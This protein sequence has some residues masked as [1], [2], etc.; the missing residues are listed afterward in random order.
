MRKDLGAHKDKAD[1]DLEVMLPG[2]G[3]S[4]KYAFRAIRRPGMLPPFLLSDLRLT[5]R[6]LSTT[7]NPE[8]VDG[9]TSIQDVTFYPHLSMRGYRFDA[10]DPTLRYSQSTLPHSEVVQFFQRTNSMAE[11]RQP[12][13]FFNDASYTRTI[14]IL[15]AIFSKQMEEQKGTKNKRIRRTIWR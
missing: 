4:S 9:L 14:C 7:F 13:N 10:A 15:M 12:T 3:L 6:R 5:L 8:T 2:D 1:Q 11:V